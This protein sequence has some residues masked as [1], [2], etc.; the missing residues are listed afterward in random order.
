MSARP[1]A[2]VDPTFIKEFG[3]SLEMMR[4]VFKAPKDSQPVILAGSGTLGY[5]CAPCNSVRHLLRVM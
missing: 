1:L 2:H 4:A 5:A 3:E